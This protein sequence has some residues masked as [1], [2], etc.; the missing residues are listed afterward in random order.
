MS[1]DF[2][3]VRGGPLG[4][5]TEY[6]ST[7]PLLL[8][9]LLRSDTGLASDKANSVISLN[10][11]APSA[12]LSLSLSLSLSSVSFAV[13]QAFLMSSCDSCSDCFLAEKPVILSLNF[14]CIISSCLSKSSRLAAFKRQREQ[15]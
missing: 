13:F 3:F 8:L 11:L 4:G 2:V 9:T 12:S 5:T 14:S 6:P 1:S 15:Y 10:R 7:P